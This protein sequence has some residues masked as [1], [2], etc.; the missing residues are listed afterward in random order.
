MDRQTL[1]TPLF[2]VYVETADGKIMPVGPR[3]VEEAV[4]K[5]AT[6]INK[7]VS[8]G[9][10]REWKAAYVMPATAAR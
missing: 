9:K 3:M 4:A 6:A 8:E 7:K 5:L 1:L 2:Q 10:E